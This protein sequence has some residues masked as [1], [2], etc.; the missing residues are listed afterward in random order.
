M[1][2]TMLFELKANSQAD[3]EYLL[4]SPGFEFFV[5]GAFFLPFSVLGFLDG[6]TRV[7]VLE[8]VAR[9][10]KK[11]GKEASQLKSTTTCCSHDVSELIAQNRTVRRDCPA[12][13]APIHWFRV[14]EM[15]R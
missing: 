10:I 14:C 2:A 15:E 1:H 3:W 5:L 13:S 11:N 12:Q 4:A 6:K 9:V 7:R 8:E